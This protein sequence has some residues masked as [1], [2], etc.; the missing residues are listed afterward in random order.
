MLPL[1]ASI[2]QPRTE[3]PPPPPPEPYDELAD[4]VAERVAIERM[5]RGE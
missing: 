5:L 3:P 2:L 1:P 4:A